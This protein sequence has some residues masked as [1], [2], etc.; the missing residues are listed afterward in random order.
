MIFYE[1]N[2][3]SCGLPCSPVCAYYYKTRVCICD[4]CEKYL[5]VYY[6]IDDNDFCQEH[7]IE[8]I[9]QN[10]KDFEKE[11]GKLSSDEDIIE[12]LEHQF[13]KIFEY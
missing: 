7:A 9:K 12:L 4:K 3:V 1:D 5:N 13:K 6:E 11:Y 2:C 10:I 8:Y